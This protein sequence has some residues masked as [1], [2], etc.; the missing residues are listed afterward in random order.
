MTNKLALAVAV[1]SG[2]LGAPSA[3]PR[4]RSQP[5]LRAELSDVV[6]GDPHPQPFP[7]RL[8]QAPELREGQVVLTQ[9]YTVD[10]GEQ[11]QIGAIVHE[12]RDLRRSTQGQK[13]LQER[14]GL[15]RVGLLGSQLEGTGTRLEQRARARHRL[16][17]C[18]AQRI[19]IED[20]VQAAK[21]E[22]RSSFGHRGGSLATPLQL[23]NL[24]T[25]LATVAWRAISL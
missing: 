1:G 12:E 10:P 14:Q 24:A 19:E 13:R 25:G 17:P 5:A 9:V 15:A 7:G 16:E 4:V 21:D 3:A 2:V 8:Q 11:R 18:T 22:R 6:S 23:A 20:R